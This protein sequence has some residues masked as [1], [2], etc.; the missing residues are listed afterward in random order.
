MTKRGGVK[1]GKVYG[2]ARADVRKDNHDGSGGGGFKEVGME[3]GNLVGS[4]GGDRT[5]VDAET[6]TKTKTDG[7]ITVD[8]AGNAS[9]SGGRTTTDT[10]GNSDKRSGSLAH[11]DGTTTAAIGRT[12]TDKD[13]N[14]QGSWSA[15]ASVT[16]KQ[17]EF[18]VKGGGS[19]SKGPAKVHA[20]AGYHSK[21]D[22]P[23]ELPDGR[24]LVSYK[25]AISGDLGGSVGKTKGGKGASIGANFSA[26]NTES[27]S[28]IFK[29]VEEANAF[30]K[31]GDLGPIGMPSSEDARKMQAGET[32][33]SDTGGGMGINA[34]G[35]YGM[36][37]AGAGITAEQGK[38]E[39]LT[40]GKGG[41]LRVEVGS[42][43]LNGWEAHA[44]LAGV[45]M[46][47][48]SSTSERKSR[49]AEFDLD[50]PDGLAAYESWR[51]TGE[52][53]YS[54]AGW[55]LVGTHSGRSDTD[56]FKMGVLGLA[57]GSS[58]TVGHSDTNLDGHTQERDWGT[59]A[60]SISI[61][62]LGSYSKSHSLQ[63]LQID[64]QRTLYNM[65][66]VVKG[67]DIDDVVSGMG[68]A[69][70]YNQHG[71][72]KGDSKGT[73]KIQSALSE[74]EMDRFINIMLKDKDGRQAHYANQV[75]SSDLHDDLKSCGGSK[76][77]QRRVLAKWVSEHGQDALRHLRNIGGKGQGGTDF[78]V[79]I[80][81]DP[82]M[83]G[84]K[85]QL[86]QE[87]RIDNWRR[88]LEN[89]EG[90]AAMATEIRKDLHWQREKKDHL[91][92]YPELPVNVFQREHARCDKNMTQLQVLM[93]RS[94]S[95]AS[96]TEGVNP[97][98]A[99]L[100]KMERQLSVAR[101]EMFGN[102][103]AAYRSRRIHND[104]L[105]GAMSMGVT[106][107]AKSKYSSSEKEAYK[108]VETHWDLA[109]LL[110]NRAHLAEQ[111]S[112]LD[113]S[114]DRLGPAITLT[115][116]AKFATEQA[117]KE[118]AEAEKIYREIYGRHSNDRRRF[119]GYS[120]VYVAGGLA[121]TRHLMPGQ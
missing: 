53:P 94:L 57:M 55:R 7:K 85:H 4:V 111:A 95:G 118:Y 42:R 87:L 112:T 34:T 70:G 48:G 108:R 82:Y 30:Y 66:T 11:K 104:R 43:A 50:K 33:G 77:R 18:G 69:T 9:A 116:R 13:G 29:T 110:S 22:A 1:D 120:D 93:E 47:G 109:E 107:S 52:L 97:Q 115:T 27:G 3:D 62:L 45:S 96:T 26:S 56:T 80:P 12:R 39:N 24:F 10:D 98:H 101:K 119:E 61:P 35:Q 28:K 25:R 76:D 102:Y 63:M 32:R 117:S 40:K 23:T 38:F 17:G 31:T 8:S 44:G 83:K 84:M 106:K 14:N 103:R 114:G 20:H 78:F 49:T 81:G 113:L 60:M 6:G 15:D 67:G 91:E 90:G 79:E 54:G 89:G 58:S 46:G 2:H 75:D 99:A 41:I 59:D 21:V 68:R 88:R 36:F 73:Y 64:N 72:E 65:E 105:A 16:N 71:R 51:K 37:E 100:L 74:P 92:D 86:D 121:S 19:I 5:T